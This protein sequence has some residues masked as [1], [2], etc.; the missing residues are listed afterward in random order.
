[1]PSCLSF[2]SPGMPCSTGAEAVGRCAGGAGHAWRR[3][4]SDLCCPMEPMARMAQMVRWLRFEF[5]CDEPG[6]VAHVDIEMP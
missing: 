5:L 6:I 4:G 1:M 3:F 2:S